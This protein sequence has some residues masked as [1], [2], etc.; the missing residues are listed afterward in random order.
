MVS[1][2]WVYINWSLSLISSFSSWPSSTSMGIILCTDRRC[3][4]VAFAY[5]IAKASI[6]AFLITL[7]TWPI[8]GIPKI[9]GTLAAKLEKSGI[10][11]AI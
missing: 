11:R 3:A 5:G 6:S 2:F 1:T 9:T 8:V 7:T 10:T 4:T